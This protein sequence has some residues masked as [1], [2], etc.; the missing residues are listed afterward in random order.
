M[1]I[2]LQFYGSM[3]TFLINYIKYELHSLGGIL[4]TGYLYFLIKLRFVF[5]TLVQL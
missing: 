4:R 5:A 3:F 1:I 2:K